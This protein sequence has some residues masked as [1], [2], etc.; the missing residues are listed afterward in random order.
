MRHF[1]SCANEIVPKRKKRTRRRR[2]SC[3]I[4]PKRKFRARPGRSKTKPL[5]ASAQQGRDQEA[6]TV[7]DLLQRRSFGVDAPST[8]SIALTCSTNRCGSWRFGESPP[9]VGAHKG[10]TPRIANFH[11]SLIVT[12]R[13]RILGLYASEPSSGGTSRCNRDM[14]PKNDPNPTRMPSSTVSLVR[15]MSFSRA[16]SSCHMPQVAIIE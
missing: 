14:K 1:R 11:I 15:L 2:F 8:Y 6:E 10:G 4:V 13:I 9:F 12:S 3:K 5:S 7:G 16:G